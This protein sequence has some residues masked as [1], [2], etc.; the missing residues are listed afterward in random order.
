MRNCPWVQ[1][2]DAQI[3][4]NMVGT[5]HRY[6][7]ICILHTKY[8]IGYDTIRSL[9][10][11]QYPGIIGPTRVHAKSCDRVGLEGYHVDEG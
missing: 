2:C 6:L 9:P 7:R 5:R 3:H 8:S 4:A 1:I 11:L 10:I